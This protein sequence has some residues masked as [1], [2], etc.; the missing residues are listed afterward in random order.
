MTAADG[1]GERLAETARQVEQHL[2]RQLDRCG[3]AGTPPRLLA[4]MRHAVLAGGKRFRPFLVLEMARV[5]GGA[6][7]AASALDTAAA[8][9]FIHAYS[10]VHDDLPA[11]DNDETRR[12]RP[13]VWK[14][15]DEWT[16]ILAGDAL[17]TLGFE[18]LADPGPASIGGAPAMSP[19]VRA[20]LIARLAAA[21]G[22]AGMVGGQMLD[23]EAEKLGLPTSPDAAHVSRLQSMKTGALIAF[24]A[25]AGAIAA[26][27]SP[28]TIAGARDYGDAIGL[29]FQISD[30]L[31]DV[32]GDAGTVGK[33]VGK[34]LSRG[35]ATLVAVAGIDAARDQLEAAVARAVSALA[36]FGAEADLLRAAAL[37]QLSRRH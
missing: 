6:G 33:A 25:E 17:L 8:I 11:M 24:A 12:G 14:A 19:K 32:T 28:A 29:A 4:A 5:V 23:L 20:R 30:D 27:A 35:K 34:D 22:A 36:G 37:F 7:A 18:I 13:T 31:L 21:A 15:Y 9:E 2:S 10:L 16:A 1:F 3:A 26:G